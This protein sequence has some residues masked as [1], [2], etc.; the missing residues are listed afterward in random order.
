MKTN[1]TSLTV[2]R[3][4][5]LLARLDRPA[6]RARSVDPGSEDANASMGGTARLGGRCRVHRTRRLG[7]R[8]Q[9]I[10]VRGSRRNP[11]F[12]GVPAGDVSHPGSSPRWKTRAVFSLPDW[13][14]GVTQRP[15][16]CLRPAQGLQAGHVIEG[17]EPTSCLPGRRVDF[18][19]WCRRP[20]PRS[21][22]GRAV[23]RLR[24]RLRLRAPFRGR[25]RPH[26]S[27]SHPPCC[28]RC[29]ASARSALYSRCR[30]RSSIDPQYAE[31]RFLLIGMVDGRLLSIV[32]T[33]RQGRYCLITARRA[34]KDEQ[35]HHFTQNS[36]DQT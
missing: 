7:Y 6:G 3:A 12:R 21:Y 17:R 29:V 32:Y 25:Q 35:D 16:R 15:H 24:L 9:A 1:V 2:T 36:Q 10:R 34:T 14:S 30:P 5:L 33:P 22:R 19:R 8:R 4:A 26:P 18:F 31:E 20:A 13:S 11:T 28:W 23:L 27:L